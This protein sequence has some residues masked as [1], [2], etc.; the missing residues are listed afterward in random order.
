MNKSFVGGAALA[1]ALCA[2]AFGQDGLIVGIDSAQEPVYLHVPGGWLAVTTLRPSNDLAVDNV[3]CTLYFVYQ[4][5]L[6]NFHNGDFFPTFVATLTYES[7][8]VEFQG[9]TFYQGHLYA[10]RTTSLEGIYEINPSTGACT[11]L[12]ATPA[13]YDFG[14]I[15][16]DQ[17]TGEMFAV[18]DATGFP[19]YEPGVY[20][21][22]LAAQTITLVTP[23]PSPAAFVS[24]GTTGARDVDGIAAANGHLYLVTDEP[25]LFADY[26][27]G[28]GTFSYFTNPWTRTLTASGAAW[29][30]CFLPAPPCDP[31][32]NQDG[33]ADLTDVFDLANDVA[34]GTESFPPNSSDFN[35]DGSADLSDILDLANVVAGGDCP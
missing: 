11:L 34:S 5:Q 6:W 28:A 9:L 20:Q 17:G 25:G 4:D 3:A 26:N 22:D 7:T 10:S 18:D 27:R 14:G 33:G 15:D 2:G 29:A 16:I 31:D 19:Q 1:A 24:S 23:Y 13:R 8:P 35:Q 30:P 12:W 32:Y 21:L